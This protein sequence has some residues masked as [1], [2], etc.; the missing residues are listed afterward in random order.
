MDKTSLILMIGGIAFIVLLVMLWKVNHDQQQK[1]AI[2]ELKEK[3]EQALIDGNKEEAI[4]C[5]RKYYSK[6]RNGELSFYDEETILRDV[7]MLAED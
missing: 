3:Y 6:I 1:E 5:G 7:S 2:R 4:D